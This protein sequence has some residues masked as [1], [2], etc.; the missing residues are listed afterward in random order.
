MWL[1]WLSMGDA[2]VQSPAPHIHTPAWWLHVSDSGT[3]EG[4][5][6]GSEVHDHQLHSEF[7]T[8]LAFVTLS[9]ERIKGSRSP[10]D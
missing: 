9:N 3:G 4:E 5:T 1:N 8:G 7:E 6:V 10:K 2:L